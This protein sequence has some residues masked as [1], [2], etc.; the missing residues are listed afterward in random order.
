[1]AVSIGLPGN[2]TGIPH[3]NLYERWL[4]YFV[5]IN[6]SQKF[7]QQVLSLYPASCHDNKS[8]VDVH[9]SMTSEQITV[10]DIK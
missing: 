6:P 10:V 1:M 9:Y 2:T 4:E 3:H 7:E 5:K 8:L